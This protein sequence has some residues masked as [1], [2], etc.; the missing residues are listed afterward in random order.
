MM[1]EVVQVSRTQTIQTLRGHAK[2]LRLYSEH[3][4][5]PWRGLEPWH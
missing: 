3:D 2:E 1:N 5:K 4:E